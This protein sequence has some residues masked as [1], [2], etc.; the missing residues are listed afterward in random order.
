MVGKKGSNGFIGEIAGC[1]DVRDPGSTRST[2]F[3]ALGEVDLKEGAMLAAKFA[4]GVN[5]FDDAGTISPSAAHTGGQ[6]D[7]GDPAP[8]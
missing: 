4:E 1:D 8:F 7:H 5:G 3:P 2:P 6:R